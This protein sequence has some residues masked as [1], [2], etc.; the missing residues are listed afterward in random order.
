M[1]MKQIME[2]ILHSVE[3]GVEKNIVC[4]LSACLLSSH[5]AH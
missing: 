2:F 1:Q 3:Y 4:W 5:T